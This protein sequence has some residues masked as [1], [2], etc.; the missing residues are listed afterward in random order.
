[1]TKLMAERI[2]AVFLIVAA[3]FAVTQT[4][5]W[6][7]RAG[8]FP[9]FA[10]YG[11]MFLAAGIFVRSFFVKNDKKLQGF[12][13]FNFS[14]LAWKPIYI[15]FLGAAYGLFVF[16][17]GFYVTSFVFFFIATYMTGFKNHKSILLCA[18]ILFPLLY[19]FFTVAL[20]AYMPEGLLF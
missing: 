9:Q 1:M 11:I 18:A 2:V 17:I 10:Q 20:D 12:V 13:S 15:L 19:L 5:G 7:S 8:S 4:Q 3:G 14:Y 16:E 6:P